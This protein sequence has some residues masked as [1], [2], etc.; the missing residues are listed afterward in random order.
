MQLFQNDIQN[1]QQNDHNLDQDEDYFDI[2][3]IEGQ[4]LDNLPDQA[5]HIDLEQ[6]LQQNDY[7]KHKFADYQIYY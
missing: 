5:S 4:D 7:L 2:P 1:A 3:E 6:I